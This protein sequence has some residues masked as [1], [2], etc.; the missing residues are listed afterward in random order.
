MTPT[1]GSRRLLTLLRAAMDACPVDRPGECG[2]RPGPDVRARPLHPGPSGTGLAAVTSRL[3]RRSTALPLET[4][5]RPVDRVEG[6]AHA[7]AS[8]VAGSGSSQPALSRAPVIRP[9]R[10][11]D[12]SSST[13][14]PRT[15]SAGSAS[16]FRSTLN[17]SISCGWNPLQRAAG[18][19]DRAP[20]RRGQALRL[21][22]YG[23]LT[24]I[25]AHASRI[26]VSR[27]ETMA[28]VLAAMNSASFG[29]IRFSSRMAAE[30]K[31]TRTTS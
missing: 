28:S 23:I 22:K 4:S 13:S 19:L 25:G 20:R 7:G 24:C 21:T 29:G 15:S 17:W 10:R 30:V 2:R 27:T 31:G 26:G 16:V 18:R 12:F 9:G 3:G 8:A 5:C 14:R 11:G 1:S 6:T